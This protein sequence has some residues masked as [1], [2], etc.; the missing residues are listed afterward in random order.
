[1]R[2]RRTV[3]ACGFAA[4]VVSSAGSSSPEL[5]ATGD[6]SSSPEL[7]SLPSSPSSARRASTSRRSCSAASAAIPACAGSG[8]G[9][10]VRAAAGLRLLVPSSSSESLRVS[11]MCPAEKALCTALMSADSQKSIKT[12]DQGGHARAHA[13]RHAQTHATFKRDGCVDESQGSALQIVTAVQNAPPAPQSRCCTPQGST[14]GGS[15]CPWTDRTAP[16]HTYHRHNA[17]SCGRVHA[18]HS[19]HHTAHTTITHRDVQRRL[20]RVGI[21][22][23]GEQSMT[24]RDPHDS[25]QR[26]D[27]I[28][29]ALH[30][31]VVQHLR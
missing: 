16:A 29:C 27:N 15:S 3:V 9:A 8:G 7:P 22:G 30:P 31:Q 17:N 13:S 14:P 25:E 19:A 4:G 11:C 5:S 12:C 20:C 23:N 26:E 2:R 24:S 6:G 18:P 1:M 10:D 28:R 21:K